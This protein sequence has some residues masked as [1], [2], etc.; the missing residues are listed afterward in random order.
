MQGGAGS[1]GKRDYDLDFGKDHV[2]F[3]TGDKGACRAPAGPIY[4]VHWGYTLPLQAMASED[5]YKTRRGD[6][7]CSDNRTIVMPPYYFFND[8]DASETEAVD[9]VALVKQSLKLHYALTS[10]AEQTEL[11]DELFLEAKANNTA[12]AAACASA[13]ASCPLATA[14]LIWRRE[15]PASMNATLVS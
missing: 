6:Q 7:P 14:T 13:A 2:L 12:L 1:R 9:S 11:I 8:T 3:F 5:S 15:C 10:T 4:M